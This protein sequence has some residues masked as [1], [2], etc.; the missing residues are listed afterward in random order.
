M[1][2]DKAYRIEQ[3]ETEPERWRAKI[4]RSD[5]RKIKVA[6][7]PGDEHDSIPTGGM[8][9]LSADAA[10]EVANRRRRHELESAGPS[11]ELTPPTPP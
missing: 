6:V 8:E 2:V 1:V 7:P 11:P 5:G 3:F 10:I 4:S 9:L